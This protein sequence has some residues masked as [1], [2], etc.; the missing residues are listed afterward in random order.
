M[1]IWPA[2]LLLL[3]LPGCI[4]FGE[5]P[6]PFLL[7]LSPEQTVQAGA[8][9]TAAAGQP[10]TID[11]PLIPQKLSTNRLAVNTG[12]TTVAY[13][14]NTQ[15]TDTPNALFRDLVSEVV[16]ARTGRVV[17]DPRQYTSAPGLV[18]GGQLH[19]FGYDAASGQVVI[20]YDAVINEGSGSVRTRRFEA[21]EPVS[22]EEAQYLAQALNRAANRVAA[23][24][25]DWIA[26]A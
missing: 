14:P 13:F 4:S 8:S 9:R 11:E 12:E 10:I 15:W 7:T 20:R 1:R 21:R 3:A 19:E 2:F 18:V 22:V 24:V 25:S 17:L 6:P 5:D 16:A 23:E 26:G